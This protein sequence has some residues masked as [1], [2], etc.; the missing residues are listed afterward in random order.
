[1][2]KIN[3]LLDKLK[4]KGIQYHVDYS[5]K[6]I[7]KVI[8]DNETILKVNAED[9]TIFNWKVENPFNEKVNYFGCD[10]ELWEGERYAN[11]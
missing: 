8:V 7:I 4:Q 11:S 5:S 3:D 1:M 10:K 6:D 2:D 9:E